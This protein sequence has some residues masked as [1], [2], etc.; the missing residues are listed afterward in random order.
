ML[1]D[2]RF[3]FSKGG[4]HPCV[5]KGHYTI[6]NNLEHVC[7]SLLGPVGVNSSNTLEEKQ[8]F[9]LCSLLYLYLQQDNLVYGLKTN[10][11]SM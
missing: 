11:E 10:K 9:F 5:E 7:G 4:P 1:G 8:C 3:E 6:Q 2:K